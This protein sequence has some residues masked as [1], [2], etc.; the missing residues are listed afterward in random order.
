M[1]LVRLC[2]SWGC[3]RRK[4]EKNQSYKA[5]RR[6]AM[7]LKICSDAGMS[8]DSRECMSNIDDPSQL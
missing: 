1:S 4:P 6:V 7:F 3:R 8:M 2:M 5:E